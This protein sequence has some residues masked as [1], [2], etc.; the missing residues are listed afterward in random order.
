MKHH[1]VHEGCSEKKVSQ[2]KWENLMRRSAHRLCFDPSNLPILGKERPSA[3]EMWGRPVLH[4]EARTL[5]CGGLKGR[6]DNPLRAQSCLIASSHLSCK[7]ATCLRNP[8]T[9]KGN[10]E[11]HREQVLLP[12]SR[13]QENPCAAGLGVR[14]LGK[15]WWLTCLRKAWMHLLF[16]W[17]ERLLEPQSLGYG[18]ADFNSYRNGRNR[19]GTEMSTKN[20][21]WSVFFVF[22]F[23]PFMDYCC[24]SGT[25]NLRASL[26]LCA[27][28]SLCSDLIL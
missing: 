12:D 9:N 21:F 11:S 15:S 26:S 25:C 5:L 13:G 23:I 8:E 20:V 6:D 14:G 16:A 4:Q 18:C 7:M 28:L 24:C 10:M 1:G 3:W 27:I 22:P 2:L 17:F 19:Q